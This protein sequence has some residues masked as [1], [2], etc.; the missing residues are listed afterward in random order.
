MTEIETLIDDVADVLE[1]GT[2]VSQEVADKY[3]KLFSQ[4]LMS[5]LAPRE[6]KSRGTLRMSNIGKPCDRQ[7][8]YDVN[9]PS[10]EKLKAH[11]KLKFL[12]GDLSELLMLAL[13]E[14]A[15]HTVEGTQDE[16][17]IEGIKG[18]RDCVI[19]GVVTDVKSASSQAFKK[20]ENGTLASNDSF[21]Y[22][23]Q[24]QSY[25]HAAKDDPIVTR[26]DVGAFL[27]LDKTL[28]H[29]CLDM[30]YRDDELDLPV[31]YQQKIEMVQEDTPPPRAFTD[32]PDG[33]SGNMKLPTNCSYCAH[34]QACWP[35]LR[36]FL[37]SNGP[38][39]LTV[40]EKV[41]QVPEV[42]IEPQEE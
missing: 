37:Y 14:I 38:K 34:N 22:I 8:W 29:F 24:L 40:V 12:Y 25:V 11:V 23:G 16:Q 39:H 42:G 18:H 19:D 5:R 7:L 15:G 6:V 32:I 9:T 30:H 36:T 28:G 4:M 13:V 26:K 35:G 21:G 1:D 27:V 2:E 3:G 31:M 17:E 20:F 10:E 33:A 41:P